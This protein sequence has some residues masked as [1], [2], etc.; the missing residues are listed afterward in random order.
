MRVGG[1]GFKIGSFFRGNGPLADLFDYRSTKDLHSS[2]LNDGFIVIVKGNLLKLCS[3]KSFVLPLF[4]NMC[5]H[6][7]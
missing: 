2:P 1:A 7:A 6:K 5:L 3:N 4:S